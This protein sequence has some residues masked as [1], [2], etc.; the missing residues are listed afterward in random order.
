M[1]DLIGIDPIPGTRWKLFADYLSERGPA[2]GTEYDFSGKE[3]FG[4]PASVA[5]PIRVAVFRLKNGKVQ[6]RLAQTWSVLW[7][8]SAIAPTNGRAAP[9][10]RE[11][12]AKG[13]RNRCE[14]TPARRVGRVA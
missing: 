6:H 10:G 7:G 3:L 5:A 8:K 11:R 13:R 14:Q 9:L 12:L 1:F 2:L 4:T